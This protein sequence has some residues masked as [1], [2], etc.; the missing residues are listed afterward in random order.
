[1]K[2]RPGFFGS[3]F[4]GFRRWELSFDGQSVVYAKTNQAP[5]R[6]HLDTVTDTVVKPGAIWAAIKIFSPEQSITCRGVVNGVAAQFVSALRHSVGQALLT[7]IG[8]HEPEFNQLTASVLR[9]FAHPRYLAHRDLEVWKS[10]IAAES[11]ASL[12]RVLALLGNPLLPRE[13]ATTEIREK[14][15]LLT[16]IMRGRWRV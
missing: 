6:I 13:G 8:G 1:M 14:I 12:A 7:A 11:K 5:I 9:L 16:R 15:D 4:T 10:A 3:L 2:I